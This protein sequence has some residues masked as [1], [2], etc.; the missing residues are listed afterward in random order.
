MGTDIQLRPT[1]LKDVDGEPRV[2][3][4][5]VAERLGFGRDRDLRKLIERNAKLL[6]M[7]GELIRATVARNQKDTP[8]AG[9]PEN[10]Y[11]LNEGQT[12]ALA[13]LSSAPVLQC[14]LGKLGWVPHSR[15]IAAN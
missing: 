5:R 9:R 8:K 4:L 10:G 14:G 11:W 7:H 2:L 3:D 12:V 1:D 6:E 13:F 15:R